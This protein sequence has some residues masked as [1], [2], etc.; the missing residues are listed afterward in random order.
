[1]NSTYFGRKEVA[2]FVAIFMSRV[3][4][5]EFVGDAQEWNQ[6]FEQSEFYS[7]KRLNGFEF[8]SE[9]ERR[10][11][12]HFLFFLGQFVPYYDETSQ[13]IVDITIKTFYETEEDHPIVKLNRQ[14]VD[15]M[16]TE[17]LRFPL[18]DDEKRVLFANLANISFTYL[19]LNSLY[20]D[21]EVLI[22]ESLY[23]E[24]ELHQTMEG[25][26]R[27]F[28]DRILK[29]PGYAKFRFSKE[30]LIRRYTN[31]V[32]PY[33]NR[34][35]SDK[36]LR[37]SIVIERNQILIMRIQNFMKSLNFLQLEEFNSEDALDY[38]VVISSS[39]SVVRDFPGVNLFYWDIEYGQKELTYL[40]QYLQRL[41]LDGGR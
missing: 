10:A 17:L 16:E 19:V 28:F 13:E 14:F 8:L 40:Y 12:T 4:K 37:V 36:K 33:K 38:D 6:F 34:Q 30:T 15:Y 3:N 7:K 27:I 29:E 11:E 2:Y 26:V 41:Y 20:P 22:G 32:Q 35:I 5:K 25:K 23:P 24:S 39:T 1:M 21:F 9:D 31:M 18:S